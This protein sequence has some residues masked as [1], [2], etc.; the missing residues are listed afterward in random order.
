MQS[1]CDAATLV[2]LQSKN[3]SAEAAGGSLGALAISDVGVD[4]HPAD[5]L[6]ERVTQEGPAAG[7][8]DPASVTSRV[9]EFAFPHIALLDFRQRQRIGGTQQLAGIAAERVTGRPAIKPF[10]ALI[11][12]GDLVICGLDEDGVIGEIEQGG[13]LNNFGGTLLKGRGAFLH[14]ALEFL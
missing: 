11:P 14:T 6:P 5:G 10:C 12:V 2:I 4:F 3:A 7:D 9:R 8:D 13:F 1:A